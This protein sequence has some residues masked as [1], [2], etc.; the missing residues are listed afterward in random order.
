L[1]LVSKL[2]KD[3]PNKGIKKTIIKSNIRNKAITHI[4]RLISTNQRKETTN[5][6]KQNAGL[7]QV[8]LH[9]RKKALER[10]KMLKIYNWSWVCPV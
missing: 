7:S 5:T 3:K 10:I 8:G 1:E 6:L 4:I 2:N 9:L